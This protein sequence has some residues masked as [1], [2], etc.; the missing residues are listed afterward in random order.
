MLLQLT[1]G[2]SPYSILS[3]ADPVPPRAVSRRDAHRGK[4]SKPSRS[5]SQQS[6]RSDTMIPSYTEHTEH[7]QGHLQGHLQV[8]N[9]EMEQQM[10]PPQTNDQWDKHSLSDA[11]TN[12]EQRSDVLQEYSTL[13]EGRLKEVEIRRGLL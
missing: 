13:L 5:Y 3:N 8:E 1:P 2:A 7:L 12:K 4:T 6:H 11:L 9:W 10:E